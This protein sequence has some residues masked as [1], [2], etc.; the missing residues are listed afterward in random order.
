MLNLF[1]RNY[2]V[3]RYGPEAIVK[4]Y[5]S[6]SHTDFVAKL[7]IQPA[8][9]SSGP[10]TAAEGQRT[11]PDF[12]AYGPGALRSAD[13]RAGTPADNVWI[14]GRWY[15]AR[16]SDSWRH[17][18]LL[19]HNRTELYLMDQQP[20]APDESILEGSGES[21][22]DG[23]QGVDTLCEGS[24]LGRLVVDVCHEGGVGLRRH[25]GGQL[26]AEGQHGGAAAGHDAR[27]CQ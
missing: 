10:T 2:I 14:D 6:A 23:G 13:Q 12:K 9:S 16:R 20:Q 19:D 3:R 4:G 22:D 8:G 7:D 24:Q 1:T 27:T 26:L 21:E 25:T 5:Y 17:I 11:L 18:G 15:E